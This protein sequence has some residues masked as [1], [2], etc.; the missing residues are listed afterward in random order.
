MDELLSA[1]QSTWEEKEKLSRQLEEERQK[2]VNA[3][4]GQVGTS[5]SGCS[6]SSSVARDRS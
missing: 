4:I 6:E 3:A 2:N 5:R 1:Q